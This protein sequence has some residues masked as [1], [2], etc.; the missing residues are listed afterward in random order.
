MET[1]NDGGVLIPVSICVQT[2]FDAAKSRRLVYS[3]NISFK[4]HQ[5]LYIKTVI[6][7]YAASLAHSPECICGM[8]A[9]VGSNEEGL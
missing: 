9:N 4:E 5:T 2:G 7:R 8:T 6:R 3:S 1:V